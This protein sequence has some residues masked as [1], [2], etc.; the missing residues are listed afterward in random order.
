MSD[1][2]TI[3]SMGNQG[4]PS[5]SSCLA[6]SQ[7]ASSRAESKGKTNDGARS[8]GV[9]LIKCEC[10]YMSL[11]LE[12]FGDVC[13]LYNSSLITLDDVIGCNSSISWLF[14]IMELKE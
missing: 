1:L 10:N 2:L 12:S 3:L 5:T 7:F 9:N 14:I 11:I 4:L 13:Y 6:G 8:Q